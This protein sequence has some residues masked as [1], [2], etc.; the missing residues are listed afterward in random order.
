M[1]AFS[2]S[3]AEELFTAFPQWRSLA[4][5]EVAAGG[6]PYLVLE[7]TPPPTADVEHG[8]VIDTSNEELTVGFD[9]YHS[10]FDE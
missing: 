6:S 10:H 1:D 7:V 3:S 2:L 5:T 4:R 8:L 9:C